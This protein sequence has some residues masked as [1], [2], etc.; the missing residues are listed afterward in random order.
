MHNK[1]ETLCW[2]VAGN[3]TQEAWLPRLVFCP[4]AVAVWFLGSVPFGGSRENLAQDAGNRPDHQQQAAG[5]AKPRFNGG[6][7]KGTHNEVLTF[8]KPKG[9]RG[10]KGHS[11]GICEG[12]EQYL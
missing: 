6:A 3:L 12:K 1:S 11:Q 8:P 7:R 10:D 4:V 9:A 5:E 2:R